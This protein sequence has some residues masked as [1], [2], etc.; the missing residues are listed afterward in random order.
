MTLLNDKTTKPSVVVEA[1]NLLFDVYSDAEFDYDLPVFVQGG[2][3]NNL[4]QLFSSVRSMVRNSS[5]RSTPLF[6]FMKLNFFFR[7]FRIKR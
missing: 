4:K 7:I 2:F 6:H 3:L 5:P 1:L